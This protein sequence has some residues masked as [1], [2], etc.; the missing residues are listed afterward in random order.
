MI[1]HLD[2]FG[3]RQ[4]R[5]AAGGYV[6]PTFAE[7]WLYAWVRHPLMLGFLI[8]F[9]CTPDMTR[10]HLLFAAAAT[11]YIAVGVWL[12]ERDLA[13]DLGPTYAEY[14]AR[15]PAIVPRPRRR[16]AADDDLQPE[17]APPA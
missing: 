14:A 10:G 9:W 15:V 7:R 3:I 1:D 8:A 6:P 12:E 11:G 13:R 5:A 17:M 2:L 16:A 4:A